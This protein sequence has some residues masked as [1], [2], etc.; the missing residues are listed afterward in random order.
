MPKHS[1]QAIGAGG[2]ISMK[3]TALINQKYIVVPTEYQISMA[4]R[5]DVLVQENDII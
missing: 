5:R 4:Q 2:D 3:R 1:A